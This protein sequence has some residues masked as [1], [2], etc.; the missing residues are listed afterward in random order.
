MHTQSTIAD[1]FHVSLETLQADV[2]G[3]GHLDGQRAAQEVEAVGTVD[4]GA[5]Q[6]AVP[7]ASDAGAG[8]AGVGDRNSV[9]GPGGV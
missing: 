6:E 2:R 1:R 8:R 9:T 4:G 7:G 5:V 3:D